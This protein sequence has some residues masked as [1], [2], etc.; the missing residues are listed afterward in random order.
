MVVE[1]A[2]DGLLEIGVDGVV[3][4]RAGLEAGG[5]AQVEPAPPGLGQVAAASLGLGGRAGTLGRQFGLRGYGVRRAGLGV[6]GLGVC[7][8][9]RVRGL[10]PGGWQAAA[11]GPRTGESEPGPR[12]PQLEAGRS[13]SPH[14][15]PM[16]QMEMGRWRKGGG[17]GGKSWLFSLWGLGCGRGPITAWGGIRAQVLHTALGVRCQVSGVRCR[18]A[19]CGCAAFQRAV[20]Y[21]G[22]KP[23]ARNNARRG[24]R[25]SVFEEGFVAAHTLHPSNALAES[26]E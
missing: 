19:V 15:P 12:K 3:V 9:L 18:R 5:L 11:R 13:W 21:H 6:R 20:A 22:E 14:I 1:F 4:A 24:Y 25:P 10:G 7:G 8:R 17:A 16:W 26:K 23:T 2:L